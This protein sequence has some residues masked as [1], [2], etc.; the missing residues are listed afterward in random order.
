M[1]TKAE[2]SFD[3]ALEQFL[4]LSKEDQH[5]GFGFNIANTSVS[6][7]GVYQKELETTKDF[8]YRDKALKLINRASQWN[9]SDPD[10][11]DYSYNKERLDEFDSVFK[12]TTAKDL[13]VTTLILRI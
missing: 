6:L 5:S 13:K 4:A 3:T 9:E 8:S 12:N 10:S 2:E 7:L 1:Y 11:Y